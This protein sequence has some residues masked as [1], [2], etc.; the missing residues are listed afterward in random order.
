[1]T[2]TVTNY[3]I[4]FDVLFFVITLH[5]LRYEILLLYVDDAKTSEASS[6]LLDI[7]ASDT[8][9]SVVPQLL[10]QETK[11]ITDD[12]EKHEVLSANQQFDRAASGVKDGAVENSLP[13]QR[14]LDASFVVPVTTV[15]ATTTC[16]NVPIPPALLSLPS[17]MHLSK[18]AL[19]SRAERLRLSA[20]AQSSLNDQV[21]P[22]S[23]TADMFSEDDEENDSF[24]EMT[25]VM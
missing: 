20:R 7:C 10:P 21:S 11:T 5:V 9:D 8:A 1:V 4:I 13:L 16:N 3:D 25:Q 18:Q 24:A 15:A 23:V 2:L 14:D 19:E 6:T 12:S 22:S 17:L